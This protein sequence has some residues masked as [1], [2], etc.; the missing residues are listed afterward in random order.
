MVRWAGAVAWH[1]GPGNISWAELAP[2]YEAFVGRALPASLHHKLWG[3]PLPLGE[4]ARVM[5]LAVRFVAAHGS[6]PT[7]VRGSHRLVPLSPTAGWAPLLGAAGTALFRALGGDGTTPAAP[8]D[9]LASAV[10]GPAP[11]PGA[12]GAFL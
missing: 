8:S 5:R 12:L 7:T 6:G 1:L 10:V 4:R 3:I 2:D 11:V 9:I